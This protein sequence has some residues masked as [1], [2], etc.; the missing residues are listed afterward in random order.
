MGNRFSVT[1]Y[2]ARLRFGQLSGGPAGT[3]EKLKTFTVASTGWL[4]F[5]S[6]KVLNILLLN[7]TFYPDVVSTVQHLGE[8]AA[9]LAKRGH[10]VAVVAGR[11]AYDDRPA[12]PPAVLAGFSQNALLPQ[13]IAVIEGR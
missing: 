1:G 8:P 13:M 12:R 10:K 2:T 5:Y 6:N 9:A 3:P 7:Q 4:P 11:R